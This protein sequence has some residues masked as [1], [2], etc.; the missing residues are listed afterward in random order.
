MLFDG[1]ACD[2]LKLFIAVVQEIRIKDRFFEMR[3]HNE[4]APYRIESFRV[5]AILVSFYLL[6]QC[7]DLIMIGFEQIDRAL[8]RFRGL[9]ACND[10]CNGLDHSGNYAFLRGRFTSGR[11]PG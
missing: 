2:L 4:L 7:L 5:I 11:L 9:I 3:V 10:V 8:R 6:E 1:F